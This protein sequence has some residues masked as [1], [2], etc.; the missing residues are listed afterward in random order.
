MADWSLTTDTNGKAVELP[1]G[2]LL[3]SA[4]QVT[5][6]FGGGTLTAQVSNDGTNFFALTTLDGSAAPTLTA[7]GI[8]EIS[9]GA[10]YIRPSFAGGAAGSITVRLFGRG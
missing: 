1:H 7:D 9:T 5:G 8:I 10:R 3:G 2:R 4:M 6:T